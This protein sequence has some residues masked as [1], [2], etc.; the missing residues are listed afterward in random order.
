MALSSGAQPGAAAGEDAADDAGCPCTPSAD[1]QQPATLRARLWGALGRPKPVL[2]PKEMS[3]ACA[4]YDAVR[5]DVRRRAPDLVIDVCGG[6]GAHGALGM[7]FVAHGAAR[8]ALIIGPSRPDSFENLRTAW[9]PFLGQKGSTVTCDERPSQEALAEALGQQRGGGERGPGGPCAAAAEDACSAPGPRPRVLVVAARVCGHLPRQIADL[10]RAAD[11]DFAVCPCD[12]RDEEGGLQAAARALGI[13]FAA[14]MVMAEMGR[15]SSSYEVRLRTFDDRTSST[16]RIILGRRRA[17]GDVAI[18]DDARDR[19]ALAEEK[20]RAACRRVRRRPDAAAP[21]RV[22]AASL[23]SAMEPL[24]PADGPTQ[25]AAST[26]PT[27]D[28]EAQLG[29]KVALVASIFEPL[30][31]DARLDPALLR[32]PGMEI[33]RSPDTHFRARTIV[34]FGAGSAQAQ[35]DPDAGG[36]FRITAD[37]EAEAGGGPGRL[38]LLA[39]APVETLLAPIAAA[40]PALP[41]L[42]SEGRACAAMRH[43]LRC[44]KLH[45][46][47]RNPAELLACFVYGP[48][49]GAAGADAL[50]LMR[51]EL[52][53]A[54]QQEAEGLVEEVVVMAQAKGVQ[55]CVPDSRDYVDEALCIEGRLLRYRQPFGQ[56]SNP[57]P[58]I[59]VATAEWL[60]DVVRTSVSGPPGCPQ[61]DLL[62]L[63]CGAGSHTVALAAAFRHVLAVEINRHLV[64]AATHNVERNALD[65]VTVLRAPSEEFCKRVLRRGSYE[66]REGG[67]VKLQLKFGCTVVDPPRA[68]LDDLTREAVRNYEHILY[69]SCNPHKL[70]VDLES[71][72]QTHEVRRL[73]LLDHFPFS[74]HVETAVHLQRRPC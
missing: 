33:R 8:R 69:V 67:L 59:A 14:A 35:T 4:F 5:R 58:H 47:L 65:N 61:T 41:R 32:A 6:Y 53:A 54:L 22:T 36:L 29:R 37:A 44:I 66:L 63:Y 1:A 60:L 28:Y 19:A 23:A 34:S 50:S 3:E 49:H 16:N 31:A 9:A 25:S 73:V 10:C 71:L 56:F 70:R 21:G 2:K 43:G 42:L 46:T 40:L 24:T 55:R 51:G 57:N 62:E 39:A 11:A 64:A 68:G 38:H 45:A 26:A 15:M 72:L 27:S 30:A 74:A 7:L 20:L 12:P 18:S 17:S 48:E 13:D 52:L